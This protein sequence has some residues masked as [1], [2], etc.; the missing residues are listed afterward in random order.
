M[1]G[2]SWTPGDA[3]Q[4]SASAADGRPLRQCRV[5]AAIRSRRAARRRSLKLD[6]SLHLA[7]ARYRA[8]PHPF[9]AV[10]GLCGA[11]ASS[12]N[13]RPVPLT[14]PATGARARARSSW[15]RAARDGP[16]DRL[17][18]G[19]VDQL[20]GPTR[21]GGH[22]EGDLRTRARPMPSSRSAGVRVSTGVTVRNMT[23]SMVCTDASQWPVTNDAR[24]TFR[25]SGN[26]S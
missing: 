6:G 19:G 13:P 22:P 5:P 17:V 8:K 12:S 23:S 24:R 15:P 26:S 1:T 18:T 7:Y 16:R 20:G 11:P 4:T 14:W 25:P 2:S 10:C 21:T 3:T 9:A